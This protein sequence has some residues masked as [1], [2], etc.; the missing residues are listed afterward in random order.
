MG[1]IHQCGVWLG[2][3]VCRAVTRVF[4]TSSYLTLQVNPGAFCYCKGYLNLRLFVRVMLS[5]IGLRK[6]DAKLWLNYCIKKSHT[7]TLSVKGTEVVTHP[8]RNWWRKKELEYGSWIWEHNSVCCV[9]RQ[10][11]SFSHT[12]PMNVN[13]RNSNSE[14]EQQVRKWNSNFRNGTAV[15]KQQ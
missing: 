14:M 6:T 15:K 3:D 12:K 10:P 11:W 9:S 1:L 4:L 7:A 2:H 8:S 13:K 5:S